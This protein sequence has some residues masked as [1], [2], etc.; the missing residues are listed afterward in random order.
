VISVLYDLEGRFL[1]RSVLNIMIISGVM[2]ST[3]AF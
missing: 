1:C 2:S 3:S